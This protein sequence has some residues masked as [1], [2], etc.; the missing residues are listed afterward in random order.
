[1]GLKV[2]Y[3]TAGDPLIH[4]GPRLM[5]LYAKS[6]NMYSDTNAY[7]LR[8]VSS[9]AYKKRFEIV[10][11]NDINILHLENNIVLL[12]ETIFN[13]RT[14][15]FIIERNT[16]FD[17]FGTFWVKPHEITK[18]L[19]IVLDYIP[20][21][22]IHV[23]AL[24]T[25]YTI[26]LAFF[27]PSAIRNKTVGLHALYHS[28]PNQL[29]NV[30]KM[31]YASL[32]VK[33]F[34]F[35]TT[36]T[37]FEA[38]MLKAFNENSVF[39]GEM[40][41]E[42]FIEQNIEKIRSKAKHLINT[43]Q[44]FDKIVLLFVGRRTK[45]KGYDIVLKGLYA[46]ITSNTSLKDKLRLIVIGGRGNDDNTEIKALE[47]KLRE[48]KVLIDLG[49]TDEITKYG[50]ILSSYVVILPSYIETIPLVFLEAWR[51]GKPIIGIDTPSI[52]SIVY[53]KPVSGLLIP[54]A[55]HSAMI[56]YIRKIVEL[57]V[58]NEF[59]LQKLKI[60]GLNGLRKMQLLFA[61]YA[62]SKRLTRLYKTVVEQG[63]V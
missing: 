6:L 53:L 36:S 32:M 11:S 55:P 15:T 10:D 37:P 29:N 46:V 26:H 50:A 8:F 35:V 58:S 59:Y 14:Y 28:S 47:R 41:N 13:V 56:S 25:S 7:V 16:H 12:E 31:C 18:A 33:R 52:R 42:W 5:Y 2:L 40:I 4:G 61:P 45:Y 48:H 19:K 49:L 23:G 3:V 62:L 17:S 57:L 39:V 27:R 44:L 63:V 54:L 1:M 21:D 51:F 34:H 60:L 38:R 22:L 20:V 24:A 9:N 30:V 43:Y